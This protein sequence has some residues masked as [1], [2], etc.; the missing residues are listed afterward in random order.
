MNR[1]DFIFWRTTRLIIG[2]ALLWLL[3][4]LAADTVIGAIEDVV[5]FELPRLTVAI[6]I[7]A[8]FGIFIFVDLR[9]FLGAYRRTA[10]LLDNDPN[11]IILLTR[12]RIIVYANPSANMILSGD[13]GRSVVGRPTHDFWDGASWESVTPYL[14]DLVYGRRKSVIATMR[15]DR[16]QE[17][18]VEYTVVLSTYKQHAAFLCVLRDITDRERLQRETIRLHERLSEA[19]RVESLG[20][21]AGGIAHDFNN[22]IAVVLGNVQLALL[23]AEEP[24]ELYYALKQIEDS[25]R[26]ARDLT[27]QLLAYAGRGVLKVAVYDL[28]YIVSQTLGIIRKS[29][30]LHVKVETDLEDGVHV[31]VDMVQAGQLVMNLVI[32]AAQSIPEGTEGIIR[33]RTRRLISTEALHD[34]RPNDLAPGSY[35]I[36]QVTDNG[37]G[38]EEDTLR[39]IFDPFF[40][41]KIK[42]TGLGLAAVLGMVKSHNG[43]IKVQSLPG[44]GTTFTAILPAYTN[45]G[46]EERELGA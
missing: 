1:F 24:S 43:G 22:L 18:I 15:V 4:T 32:N 5:G 17:C 39:R 42:G 21:L 3:W 8:G 35:V 41:T 30:P 36:L 20:I 45:G 37:E 33:V 23:D 13:V 40:T 28:N 11:G 31:E 34:Y 9:D 44:D 38:I 14:E 16:E 46:L 27:T 19:D 7:S 6:L 2:Y 12:E 10:G 29:I 25:A 26:R